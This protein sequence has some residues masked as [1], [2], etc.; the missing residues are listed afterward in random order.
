MNLN[1]ETATLGTVKPEKGSS[2]YSVEVKLKGLGAESRKT[3]L[4]YATVNAEGK[5]LN[6]PQG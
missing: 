4:F 3:S 5:V 2:N 1:W 6:V